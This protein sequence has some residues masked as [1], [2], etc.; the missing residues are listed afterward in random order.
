MKRYVLIGLFAGAAVT[1]L[2]YL[3]RRRELEGSEFKEFFDSSSVADDLFGD[4]F[5]E[6]PDKP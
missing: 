3:L 5:E 2:V 4:A 6:L 1:F